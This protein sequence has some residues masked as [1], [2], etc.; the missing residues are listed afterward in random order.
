MKPKSP[1]QP[2]APIVLESVSAFILLLLQATV[3]PFSLPR[4]HQE[5]ETVSRSHFSLRNLEKKNAEEPCG[6]TAEHSSPTLG[7]VCQRALKLWVNE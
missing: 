4:H 6:C 7:K 3:T 2:S 5:E 1:K